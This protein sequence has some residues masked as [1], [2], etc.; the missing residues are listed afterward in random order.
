MLS[1]VGGGTDLT[2]L[3]ALSYFEVVDWV[4]LEGEARKS[5]RNLGLVL[6]VRARMRVRVRVRAR[7]RV[8][9]SYVWGY[10]YSKIST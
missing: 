7:V 6:R 10:R 9:W 3:E 4:K 5:I 2:N 1:S 8:T